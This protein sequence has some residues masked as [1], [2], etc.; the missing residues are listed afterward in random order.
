MNSR[1]KSSFF[2]V[3]LAVFLLLGVALGAHAEQSVQATSERGE[4]L[5][6]DETMQKIEDLVRRVDLQARI[7]KA[8]SEAEQL[9]AFGSWARRVETSFR[10]GYTTLIDDYQF[11][12]RVSPKGL[13]HGDLTNQDGG[14]NKNYGV[15]AD[16]QLRIQFAQ[17]HRGNGV[18]DH[19]RLL[20]SNIY[21]PWS[22]LP[23]SAEKAMKRMKVGDFVSVQAKM[24]ILTSANQLKMLAPHFPLV[25]GAHYMVSGEFQIHVY[26]LMNDEKTD[27][28]R[29]RVKVIGVRGRESGAGLRFGY[30]PADDLK[31]TRVNFVDKILRRRLEFVPFEIGATIPRSNLFLLDYVLNFSDSEARDAYDALIDS[32]WHPATLKYLNPYNSKQEVEDMLLADASLMGEVFEKNKDRKSEDRGVDR[33]F[34]GSNEILGGGGFFIRFGQR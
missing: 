6:S 31:I 30:D 25:L 3:S 21:T 12:I 16:G 11:R 9:G 27:S 20:V 13:N 22:N 4:S 28:T 29:F 7:L 26:R 17:Q 32:L 24:N 2:E 18:K 8:S 33:M 23:M 19:L 5:L 34:R 10:Q 1:T 14:E 15:S